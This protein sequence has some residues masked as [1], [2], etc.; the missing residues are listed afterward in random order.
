MSIFGHIKGQYRSQRAQRP[1]GPSIIRFRD[2]TQTEALSDTH[3]HPKGRFESLPE[4]HRTGRTVG[5]QTTSAQEDCPWKEIH[6]RPKV[7]QSSQDGMA[8]VMKLGE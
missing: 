8:V 5:G 1:Q 2:R 4:H 3:S 6:S 7:V